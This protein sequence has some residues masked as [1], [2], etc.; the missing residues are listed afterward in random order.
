MNNA[1]SIQTAISVSFYLLWIV[2]FLGFPIGGSLSQLVV[3]PIDTIVKGALGGLITGA[4]I[5][6]AEWLVLRQALPALD[7]RWALATGIGMALGLGLGVALFGIETD[8][9]QMILRA[10]VTGLAIGI[11]QWLVLREFVD[12]SAWWVLVMG[13]GWAIAWTIT[14]AFGVDMTKNWSVFGS[15]GAIIFQIITAIALRLLLVR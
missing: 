14:R 3:G 11:A 7:L 12:S 4:V 1:G 13:G 15:S 9:N 2:A 5:G 8:G 10:A 6:L